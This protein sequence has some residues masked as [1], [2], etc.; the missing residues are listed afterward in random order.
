MSDKSGVRI[1][2]YVRQGDEAELPMQVAVEVPNL[3]RQGY[4]IRFGW[5]GEDSTVNLYLTNAQARDLANKLKAAL[6]AGPQ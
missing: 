4:K 1:D 2:L 3:P 5:P 6:E